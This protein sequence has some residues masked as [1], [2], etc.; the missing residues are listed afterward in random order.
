MF[1]NGM[2]VFVFVPYANYCVYTSYSRNKRRDATRRSHRRISPHNNISA[3][4]RTLWIISRHVVFFLRLNITY[5]TTGLVYFCKRARVWG[6]RPLWNI[7]VVLSAAAVVIVQSSCN[8]KLYNR[9][10]VRDWIRTRRI[11]TNK[12]TYIII[13]VITVPMKTVSRVWVAMSLYIVS[14][15]IEYVSAL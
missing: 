6:G 11:D 2:D 12:I 4:P 10:C 14:I 15:L 9:F 3:T 8:E 1:T 5:R 13:S 7:A